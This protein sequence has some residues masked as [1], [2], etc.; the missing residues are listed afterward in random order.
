MNAG[1]VFSAA[2]R[3]VT[4]RNQQTNQSTTGRTA[5]VCVLLVAAVWIVFGQTARFG[6]VNYDDEENVYLNPVVSKGLSSGSAGWAFTHAQTSNWVPL[7]TLSHMLDCQL[8]GLNAGGHHAVNVLWHAANAVLLFLI[9]REMTGRF[10][11]SAFVA[12][13]FAVHPLRAESVAWVS[14]RK[15]VMS[16]FFFLL[17]IWAYARF[18]R[19]RT[20]GWYVGLIVLFVLGLLAKTM[21]ATLPF[22]L[23]LLD[24]WP[25][26]RL[27]RWQDLGKLV[28]EKTPLFLLSAISCVAAAAVPNF[29]IRNAHRLTFMERLSN[30]LVAYAVYLKEMVYPSDLAALY[31]VAGSAMSELFLAAAV[32]IVI[33]VGVVIWRKRQP[34][35]LTG[36]FWYLGMLFPVIGIVQIS[37][38]AAHA[39]RYTYLPEIGLVI[40]VT[41][42]AADWAAKSEERRAGLG[43][44]MAAVVGVLLVCGFRQASYWRS[45]ETLWTRAIEV[46]TSNSMA[47]EYLGAALAA[48]GKMKP[49][50]EQYRA[51]LAIAPDNLE[52][53]NNLGTQLAQ[54]GAGSGNNAKVDEAID[55]FRKAL[56]ID[57]GSKTAHYNLA[58]ALGNKGLTQ[59]A[60]DEYH[61]TL[62]LD[63][64]LADAHV[65]LGNTLRKGGHVD[66][67]IAEYQKALQLNPNYAEAR[68]SL[69]L[70]YYTKG[71]K[72]DAIQ[73]YKK[74]LEIDPSLS[75]VRVNLAD[76]L[77]E[78]GRKEESFAEYKKSAEA[79]PGYL[80]AEYNWGKALAADKKWDESI[81][82][83]RK[84]L[85]AKPD[86][87]GGYNTL[88]LSLA[89][90]GDVKGA[91][92]CWKEALVIVPGQA[93][94]QNNLAWVLATNPDASVRDGAQA[95]E[96]AEK[97]NIWS[98][99]VNLT[100]LH[101]LAA[102]YAE[103]GKFR[104]AAATARHAMDLGA[105]RMNPKLAEMLEKEIKL[106]QT[107][108]PVR[109]AAN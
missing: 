91:V 61:K 76:A 11:Q 58:V 5:L 82:H 69:A 10:W 21:V 12:A 18:A 6:F 102:A 31:P 66:D 15:D 74:A 104:E 28:R 40:A 59:E 72:E 62:A 90:K 85:K 52:A 48:E 89:G 51:A 103:T 70:A 54:E 63:P 109:E 101:T 43:M 106:Y 77:Y 35:L 23:L 38:A 27:E 30:G 100:V 95:V 14:E 19:K 46:T 57:P 1:G 97:A 96:L 7:T 107:N 65:N 81:E 92:A 78:A 87:P 25:L 42:A 26:R 79:D 75:W 55:C 36:W 86:Y 50:M 71:K 68:A 3:E 44:A 80:R 45:G 67:G 98:R 32:W 53:L 49:A 9:L 4:K 108:M 105:A 99:G 39:D 73:E 56:K 29:I 84:V 2:A 34:W 83:L 13:V 16:G 37:A 60:I 22:V 47:H 93:D 64:N 17:S 20:I 88:A 41:W 24:Y 33:T 8:F 94:V